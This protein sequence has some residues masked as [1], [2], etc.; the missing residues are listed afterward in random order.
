MDDSYH[1]QIALL[2]GE[3]IEL[4]IGKPEKIRSN[5]QNRYFHS[6][7]VK[8]ISDHTG[9]EKAEVKEMI[10][11]KFLSYDIKVGEEIVKVGKSTASLTTSEFEDLNSECR[12]WASQVMDL[13]L[14]E[15]NEVE[16]E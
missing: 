7:I 9:Y 12:R 6:V 13:Y 3:E 8:G 1:K 15:P 5:P 11:M 2:E 14:A 16:Y 10:R 4:S